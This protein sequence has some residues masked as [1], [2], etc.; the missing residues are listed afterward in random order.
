M[1]PVYLE[2]GFRGVWR[3]TILRKIYGDIWLLHKEVNDY[4][5]KATGKKFAS[6]VNEA[7]M[8]IRF[9]GDVYYHV[10]NFLYEKGF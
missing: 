3:R 6:Y 2:I 9:K 1:L 7:A 5:E 4:V 8:L 10:E